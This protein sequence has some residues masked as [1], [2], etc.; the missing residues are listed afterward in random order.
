MKL[1]KAELR[2]EGNIAT[3]VTVGGTSPA[4]FAHAFDSQHLYQV[5][6]TVKP[7]LSQGFEA[8]QGDLLDRN[9]T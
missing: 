4:K 1:V 7:D 2:V 6:A 5:V 9:A 3:D 8:C